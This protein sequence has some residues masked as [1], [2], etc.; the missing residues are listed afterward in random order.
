MKTLTQEA[1]KAQLQ[2]L[3]AGISSIQSDT[4]VDVYKKATEEEL[5]A[6]LQRIQRLGSILHEFT[7]RTLDEIWPDDEMLSYIETRLNAFERRWPG[8]ADLLIERF[9]KVQEHV[10][11]S[12]Q[13]F[14][15]AQD[16]NPPNLTPQEIGNNGQALP[17][18]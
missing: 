6:A 8:T 3:S 5:R 17:N 13:V 15:G 4:F 7:N 14:L 12:A 16:I 18:C 9:A 11:P 10:I 2:F 1:V